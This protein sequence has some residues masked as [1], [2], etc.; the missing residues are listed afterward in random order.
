[1]ENN[2][3]EPEDNYKRVRRSDRNKKEEVSNPRVSRLLTSCIAAGIVGITP[4]NEIAAKIVG[5]GHGQAYA[6]KYAAIVGAIT[7]VLFLA[8]D[9]LVYYIIKAIKKRIR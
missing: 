6:Q 7:F 4:V 3:F 8:I 9:V 1:M 5:S 2:G